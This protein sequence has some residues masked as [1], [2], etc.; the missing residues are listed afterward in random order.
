MRLSVTMKCLECGNENYITDKNK[1]NTP[2][3]MEFKKYCPK[4][5]KSTPH[6]EKK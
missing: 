6:R 4:C 1:R 5:N 3:R 2:N